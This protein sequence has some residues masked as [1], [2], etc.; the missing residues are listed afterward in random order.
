MCREL[1]NSMWTFLQGP[2]CH[3]AMLGS[4][5]NLVA[6]PRDAGIAG[7]PE[8][9][10]P[11]LPLSLASPLAPW[12]ERQRPASAPRLD[13][14]AVVR[15]LRRL[16]RCGIAEQLVRPTQV[17]VGKIEKNLPI[18]SEQRVTARP[19]IVA[20]HVTY[21]VA[22]G[23]QFFR[24]EI[25]RS[26]QPVYGSSGA[27]H[28]KLSRRIDPEIGP[29]IGEQDGTRS[30]QGNQTVLVERQ[31]FWCGVEFLEPRVEPMRKRVVDVRHRFRRSGLRGV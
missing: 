20:K 7:E 12:A 15:N 30:T 28:F 26:Q 24:C 16:V 6:T 1:W 27:K 17:L 21:H 13:P 29:T 23:W 3:A 25:T 5:Q 9:G 8:A 14:A 10:L 11:D 31:P 19:E 4:I 2:G 18:L 22:V